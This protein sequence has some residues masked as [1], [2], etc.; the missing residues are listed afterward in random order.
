MVPD[1][2]VPSLLSPPTRPSTSRQLP[3][4]IAI[5]GGGYIAV[6]F[7]GIF[8]GLGVETTLLYRGAKILRGFDEDLRE[9]LTHELSKRGI[10]V[11]CAIEVASIERGSSNHTLTLTDGNTLHVDQVM[12]ATGRSPN[13]SGVGLELAGVAT[14]EGRDSG[15]QA[16]AH[17]G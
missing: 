6:E 8:N 2:P 12:F 16:V 10:D 14:G 3:R 1:P 11:R 15:R 13:T 5:V 7:A 17:L 9:G 4:S